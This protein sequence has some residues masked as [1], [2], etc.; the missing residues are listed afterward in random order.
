MRFI[1]IDL[2]KDSMTVACLDETGNTLWIK[3]VATKCNNQIA[4]LFA[5]IDQ[6]YAVA[7]EAVGFYHWLWDLL[8]DRPAQKF[9]ANPVEIAARK[10]VKRAKTDRKDAVLIAELL[11]RGEIPA[12]Y[13]PTPEE[14]ELREI[15]RHRHAIARKLASAKNSFIRICL[16]R[17]L[18]GPK[19]M[20]AERAIKFF[21]SWRERFAVNQQLMLEDLTDQI[22]FLERQLDKALERIVACL[23]Y[24]CF[25]PTLTLYASVPGIATVSAATIIA[26]TGNI[27]RFDSAKEIVSYA[28]LAPRVFQSADTC[29]HGRISKAGP[30]NLRWILVQTAWCAIRFDRRCR[31]I[32]DRIR[33][34]AGKKKAVCAVARRLLIWLWAMAKSGAPYDPE[35]GKPK[36]DTAGP[37]PQIK[38]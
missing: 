18:D 10:S 25:A 13:V 37:S 5:E 2:H 28:G 7:V 31:A 35:K 34:R 29:R 36:N 14:R 20:N 23:R 27:R 30:K 32:F 12:V 22:V 3:T 9:L 19:N 38:P 4:T 15:T 33:V 1:G 17:N 8:G 26:E 6:P 24:P 11:R 21:K 16:K